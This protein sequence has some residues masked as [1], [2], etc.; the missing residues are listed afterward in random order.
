MVLSNL[1]LLGS[2]M[3]SNGSSNGAVNVSHPYSAS[4]N[5]SESSINLISNVSYQ[6]IVLKFNNATFNVE[7]CYIHLT[8]Y[9]NGLFSRYNINEDQFFTFASADYENQYTPTMFYIYASNP[10][11][12]L[13]GTFDSVSVY[14]DLTS[15]TS[16][17]IGS[18]II[19]TI[20]DGLGLMEDI[21]SE[22]LT[23]FTT[24]FWKDNQLTIFG[25]F[26]LIFMGI[27]ITFS[28]IKLC[29]NLI[30]GKTGA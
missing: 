29:L 12:P 4:F 10:D 23:G 21:A 20:S 3:F 5:L 18:G 16:S 25:Q 14:M 8:N 27:S 13:N 1:M 22:F 7:D 2:L 15:S 30:R 6:K 28:I 19:D 26:A 24:L 9:P 11:S 17:T